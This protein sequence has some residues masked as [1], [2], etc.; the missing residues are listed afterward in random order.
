[1][2]RHLLAVALIVWTVPV[3]AAGAQSIVVGVGSSR[4]ITGSGIKQVAVS[5]PAVVDVQPVT[6]SEVLMIGKAPG[7]TQVFVWDR[8]GRREYEVTVTS[9][10]AGVESFAK[11]IQAE[12]AI[13]GVTAQVAGDKVL[14]KGEVRSEEDAKR[15]EAVAKALYPKVENVIAVVPRVTPGA[16]TAINS[17]LAKWGLTAQDA[18]G[19]VLIG[20]TVRDNAVLGEV[21]KT[22]KPWEKEAQFILNVD[23][24]KS[25]QQQAADSLT[26][27]MSKWAIKPVLL[28]DG[29]V[30]VQGT[31]PS[32][33]ALA[34]AET[35]A[36]NWPRPAEVVWQIGIAEITQQKQ[37]LIRARLV[38]IDRNDLTDLGVDWSRIVF[39]QTSGSNVTYSAEDQPFIIGQPRPGP[40]PIFGGPPI[41]QLDPIGARIN[42]LIQLN[43][44]HVLT[45]PTLVTAS[46]QPANILIGGEIPVPVPQAGVGAGAAITIVYKPFGISLTVLPTAGD[47]CEIS[48]MVK[49]EVSQLDYANGIEISGFVVPALKTRRAESSV[50][51]PSGCSIAI[52]GL[53]ATEDIK[54]IKEIPL[55]SKI[56]VLGNFF[57]SVSTTKR[58][59][60]LIIVVTPEL[61]GAPGP[62]D[63]I[64]DTGVDIP[65][66]EAPG[67]GS[68]GICSP[69]TLPTGPPRPAP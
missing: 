2:V 46:G 20:G 68:S 4:I 3:A 50:H 66:A 34:E 48:M 25:P 69:Q 28:P 1:M 18:E 23:L 13:A 21:A 22:L 45:Q 5:D 63:V 41:E 54:S 27:I 58:K 64:K 30:L 53:Y 65:T 47:N 15:A 44:A 59:S 51:V 36:K 24:E 7:L 61:V 56:P 67:T 33:E 10:K 40:F 6:S 31:V 9:A 26:T 29:R 32:K 17:A 12:I 62:A 11:A 57:R 8:S 52:G 35:V 43:K 42:A 16:L 39:S 49:P 37:I 55:L 14:L 38:E 19:K 60:E